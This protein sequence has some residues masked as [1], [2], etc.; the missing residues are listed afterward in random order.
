MNRDL[1]L[2]IDSYFKEVVSGNAAIFA[3]AGLSAP[4]GFVNWKGLMRPLA[5]ELDV[6]IDLESD[7]IAIAQF[8]VNAN[9]GIRAGINK[10]LI[11]ALSVD[12]PPTL[13]HL[14]LARLPI[15]TW[16]TTNYD[17]LIET[18][19]KEAGRIVEVKWSVPQL[20]NTRPRRDA[21]VYKMHG[22]IDRP[23]EAVVTR[24][25]YER[26]A[27]DRGAFINALAGDLASKTFLFLGF[28]FTDP[29]LAQVLA[30]L[31]IAFGPN[32][33]Q[34]FAI[35]RQPKRGDY[36][37]DDEFKHA[38]VMQ[39]LTLNDLRRFSVKAILVD[40]YA[41]ITEAIASI[42]R[43]YRRRTVFVSGSAEEFLTWDETAVV[44]FMRAIGASLIANGFRIVTGMGLGL[45]TA[46]ISG[47]IEAIL[48]RRETHIEDVLVM[49]P[50]PRALSDGVDKKKIYDEYRQ[51]MIGLAGLAL[52]LFGNRKVDG[53]I[54][55]SVGTRTE[56][57]IARNLELILLP[58]GAT[59]YT[60]SELS[61]EVAADTK[62]SA[63]HAAAIKSLAESEGD[64]KALVDSIV[65][66][67]ISLRDGK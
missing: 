4:A 1:Q 48:E 15:A 47:A 26:Y 41:E 51:S 63:D 58:V 5:E 7:L 64:L 56:F 49:R 33:K 12:K 42:E 46:L 61:R 59:G 23:D 19:L 6:D 34:H 65:K 28:S 35:F 13:N 22:D 8:Y 3:G 52:F 16:W 60:A 25:D 24:D 53:K 45:G 20:A 11:E 17:K 39:D 31:R 37:T 38:R 54:A 50:F 43:R 36:K 9:G 14:L 27:T 2:F 57:E 40:E 32:Q 62:I 67:A 55:N 18:S 30:R 21:V 10:A 44:A 29:N 66:A